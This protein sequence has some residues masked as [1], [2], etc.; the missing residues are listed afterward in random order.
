MPSVRSRRF[1]IL[2]SGIITVS[3]GIVH[4]TNTPQIYR[5]SL[6]AFSNEAAR[7]RGAAYFFALAG[8]LVLYAGLSLVFASLQLR[9]SE[10]CARWVIVGA[11]IVV[12]MVG[13]GAWG[14]GLKNPLIWLLL[15]LGP[16]NIILLFGDRW[17]RP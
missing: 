15:A 13:G 4:I 7:A 1:W 17:R 11:S 10:V 5:Q 8:V 2:V 6:R 12:L 3:I 16:A 14:V 9:G